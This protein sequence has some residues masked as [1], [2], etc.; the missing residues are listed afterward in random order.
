VCVGFF[1]LHTDNMALSQRIIPNNFQ[2]RENKISRKGAKTL[3]YIYLHFNCFYVNILIWAAGRYQ[4]VLALLAF[5]H[6]DYLN[7]HTNPNPNKTNE[8]DVFDHLYFR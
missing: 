8:S 4:L 3:K 1:Y 6:F 5:N 7:V 2:N